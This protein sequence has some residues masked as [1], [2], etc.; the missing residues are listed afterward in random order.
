MAH[1]FRNLPYMDHLMAYWYNFAV[2]FEAVFIL[3]AIDAGT[4]VGRFFLQ[5][6]MGLVYPKFNDKEWW[7]GIILSSAVFTFLWGYL[8]YTGNISSIWPLFGLSNQLLAACALIVCTTMLL[9]LN[10]GVYA[11]AVAIPGIFMVGV[12]FWAGYLQVFEQ[13]WP[14]KQYLLAVLGLLV[15]FLM[16]LVL[17]GTFAKWK[18]LF[19]EKCLL[20]D[21][22]GEPV[23]ELAEE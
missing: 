10:R 18:K 3:T 16:L 22:Y 5:E 12:T 8:V 15:M 21:A 11:L 17:F 19:A 23:R 20:K 9:R 2:M 13:Y 6:M 14:Q 1:I 4:R 7:P